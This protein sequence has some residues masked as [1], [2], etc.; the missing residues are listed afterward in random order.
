MVWQ[1]KNETYF[2]MILQDTIC[3]LDFEFVFLWGLKGLIPSHKQKKE[4]NKTVYVFVL[5]IMLPVL[6]SANFA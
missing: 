3:L 5:F 4:H 1:F 6:L 2:V